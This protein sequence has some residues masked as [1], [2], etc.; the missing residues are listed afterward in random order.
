MKNTLNLV[1]DSILCTIICVALLILNS[2]S[3]LSSAITIMGIVLFMGCFFQNKP[4]VR[5][6]LSGVIIVA[7]C[8]LFVDPLNILIFILP[9]VILGILSSVFLKKLENNKLFYIILSPVFF[10]VNL[11]SELLFAKHIMNMDFLTYITTDKMVEVPDT[12]A[13]NTTL[14]LIAYLFVL[15][16]ISVLEVIVLQKGN[17]IYKKRIMKIIGEEPEI[18]EE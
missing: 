2:V 7:V 14:F 5:P 15:A 6:I 9:G 4:I 8:F 17:K 10:V 11:V 18:K 1:K 12:L 3:M 16:F 13:E